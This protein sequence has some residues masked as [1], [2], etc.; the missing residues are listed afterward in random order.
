MFIPPVYEGNGL[1]TDSRRIEVFFR[2]G[3]LAQRYLLKMGF[4]DEKSKEE[5]K[6][7]LLVSKVR[8]ERIG[9][10]RGGAQYAEFNDG[11]GLILQ[12]EEKFRNILIAETEGSKERSEEALS[13]LSERF[14]T[15]QELIEFEKVD[16][17]TQ[18]MFGYKVWK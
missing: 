4:M 14:K 10:G 8:K 9:Y 3:G 5:Y 2:R 13:R 11:I 1:I 15:Y 17:I 16:A 6:R 12:I 18:G 7:R